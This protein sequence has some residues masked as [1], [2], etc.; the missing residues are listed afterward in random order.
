MECTLI[1]L[2]DIPLYWVL[3]GVIQIQT[4]HV[5][6]RFRWIGCP[7]QLKIVCPRLDVLQVES[8]LQTENA[9]A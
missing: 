5:P 7:P 4:K 1:Y 2:L 8:S 9:G 6:I 3:Y